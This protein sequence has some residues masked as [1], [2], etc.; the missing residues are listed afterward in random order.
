MKKEN[1]ASPVGCGDFLHRNRLGSS[2][3]KMKLSLAKVLPLSEHLIS[4]LCRQWRNGAKLR[5][6]VCF[7]FPTCISNLERKRV[8]RRNRI[9][10]KMGLLIFSPSIKLENRARYTWAFH[11]TLNVESSPFFFPTFLLSHFSLL[12]LFS[13]HHQ[14]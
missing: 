10:C 9:A 3:K 13:S 14:R 8:A 12:F 2:I 5:A 6:V 11:A 7:A 1:E 4:F